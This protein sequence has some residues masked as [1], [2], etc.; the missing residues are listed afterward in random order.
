MILWCLCFLLQGGTTVDDDLLKKIELVDMST[1]TIVSTATEHGKTMLAATS[2]GGRMGY[3]IFDHRDGQAYT[4]QDG[5]VRTD[6][7]SKI[8]ATGNGFAIIDRIALF[9]Y[10]VDR[11]GRFASVEDLEGYRGFVPDCRPIEIAP[12]GESRFLL[13]YL[14]QDTEVLALAIVDLERKTFTVQHTREPEPDMKRAY[15]CWDGSRMYHVRPENGRIDWVDAKNFRTLKVIRTARDTVE[16]PY[17]RPG[18]ANASVMARFLRVLTNP[19]YLKDRIKLEI[20]IYRARDKRVTDRK[21]GMIQDGS[22]QEMT[23]ETFIVGENRGM[24]LIFDKENG[25]FRVEK[26]R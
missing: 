9:A 10:H 11:N 6:I 22:F 17:F 20:P 5:R 8:I 15:W 14:E 24:R 7:L 23:S 18:A 4:L 2:G 26:R 3:F 16:N 19:L 25:D 1:R 21:L 12:Y 13:T